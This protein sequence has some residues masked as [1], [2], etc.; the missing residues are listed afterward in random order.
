MHVRM[1]DHAAAGSSAAGK[2]FDCNLLPDA[3][4]SC[5]LWMMPLHQFA[6][7][8][9]LHCCWACLQCLGCCRSGASDA[10]VRLTAGFPA[11]AAAEV[12]GEVYRR[13]KAAT[14][15]VMSGCYE[16][17]HD[18]ATDIVKYTGEGPP[19]WYC[20]RSLREGPSLPCMALFLLHETVSQL[21]AGTFAWTTRM[22]P[23][24]C[25]CTV[26]AQAMLHSPSLFV[27]V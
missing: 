23:A 19:G 18:T 20:S 13:V 10:C 21:S 2:R 6:C 3:I 8:A 15:I 25:T 16:D 11:A 1:T 5:W 12:G 17:D 7:M 22:M 9:C 26:F 27:F 24:P 14:S 4:V